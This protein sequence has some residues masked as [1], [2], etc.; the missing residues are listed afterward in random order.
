MLRLGNEILREGKVAVEPE[1]A[2]A[3]AKPSLEGLSLADAFGEIHYQRYPDFSPRADLS[4]APW[5]WTDD[6]HMAPSIVGMPSRHT[7]IH[8]D[9]VARAI[10]R[11]YS[12][13]LHPGYRRG[14]HRLLRR[15][16]RGADSSE[17]AP[18]SYRGGSYGKGASA[19]GAP[20]GAH[21]TAG[22]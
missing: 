16:S 20:I 12:A 21:L 10:A 11:R 7:A 1:S 5:P 17:A 14:A 18:A 3:R 8:Q 9:E 4:A 22:G 19:R 2:I 15:I 13:D 6:T